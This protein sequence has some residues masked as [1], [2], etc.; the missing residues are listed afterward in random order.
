MRTRFWFES[1]LTLA[2]GFL[3]GLT[4][5]WRDWIEAVLH[6]DPDRHNGS[7]EGII[8]AALCSL[9]LA[10]GLLTRSEWRRRPSHL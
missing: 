9:T 8:A 6:V 7:L 3:L 10:L 2:S 4:L 1:A 5:V